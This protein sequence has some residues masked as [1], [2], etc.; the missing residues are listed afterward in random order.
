MD[1]QE[2]F[3]QVDG[4]AAD[5]PVEIEDGAA[6]EA[7]PAAPEWTDEDA[8]AAKML[9][10]KDP[11][12]WEGEKPSGFID[13]PRRFLERAES[14]G[15]FRKLKERLDSVEE[16]SR[17]AADIAAKQIE[18][19]REQEKAEYER[20]LESI[21]RAQREAVDSAD[22]EAFDAL[23]KRRENLAA[24]SDPEPAESENTDPL[25]P[26]KG[27]TTRGSTT[28][29]SEITA[30]SLSGRRFKRARWR[31]AIRRRRWLTPKRR[32]KGYYPHLFEDAPKP[33]P[34]AS[35]VA[36]DTIAPFRRK[37]GFDSL[38]ADAKAVFKRQVEQGIFANTPEDK[39]FFSNEYASA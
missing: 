4:E 12:E 21:R 36:G 25:E 26:F 24:P 17:K 35:P 1:E 6:H 9:G 30:S 20:E 2:E 13:D 11:G 3:E 5:P 10:W 39:E 37:S 32:L 29:F 38:P 31:R 33:K 34:K 7:E 19:V 18:R 14:F 28:P 8:E 23:E 22:A 15:P 16:T 27:E